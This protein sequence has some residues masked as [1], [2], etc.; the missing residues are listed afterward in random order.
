MSDEASKLA[1]W[2]GRRVLRGGAYPGRTLAGALFRRKARMRG[3]SAFVVLTSDGVTLDAWYA[4]APTPHADRLP[5]LIMHGWIEV[6]EFY[7]QWAYRLNDAGHDV[8]LFDHRGHGRSQK[9]AAT[10]GVRERH[11][12]AAVID[13]ARARGLIGDQLLTF[14][15]SMGA[16]TALQH[17]A[18]DPRVAGVVAFAPFS[19]LDRA[20]TSFRKLWAPW[21]DDDWLQRG[22]RAAAT[23][24]G[25]ELEQADTVEAVRELDRPVLL[26]EGATDRALPPATHTRLIDADHTNGRVRLYTVPNANHFTLTRRDWPGLAQTVLDFCAEVSGSAN[27]LR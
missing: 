3:G 6:K 1:T 15:H 9:T 7:Y 10:F 17:A 20:V 2:L 26:I 4:P 27:A 19:T 5:V 18:I 14:G 13:N 8:I 12:A 24:A 16:A 25:F 21:V 22:V 23:E 11:D